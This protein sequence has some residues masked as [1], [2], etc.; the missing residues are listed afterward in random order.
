MEYYQQVQNRAQQTAAVINTHLPALSVGGFTAADLLTQRTALDGLAATRDARLAL[1][2]QAANAEFAGYNLI[3]KMSLDLPRVAE[4]QL[5]DD[6]KEEAALADLLDP[7]YAIPPDTTERAVKRGQKVKA[8]L[9]QIDPYLA[10][11]TPPRDP[12]TAGGRGLTELATAITAQ[13]GLESSV[14]TGDAQVT[15]QR[16]TLRTAARALDRL[17]K[18]SY[19][20]LQAEARDNPALA[21]AL[22][23]IET[24]DSNLPPTLGIRRV[25]QG[26]TG[27][28]QLLVSYDNGSFDDAL[29]NTVE[30]MVENVDQDFTHTAA[31]DP[32][33][34]AIGPF[35][36]GQVVK[37]R[38]RTRNT[39]GTTTGSVRTLTIQV[40]A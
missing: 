38:T 29:T 19:K 25:L 23:Q 21:D 8:A 15:Q 2:D 3:R 13:Q 27:G 14:A 4:G 28:L 32:S 35:T 7:A 10:G 17:N 39:N 26:G 20:V 40:P 12:I 30:W 6:V 9:Q 37:L 33:G 22:S 16:T 1:A 11:L 34:N 18:R 24:D 5:D 31:A 36:A